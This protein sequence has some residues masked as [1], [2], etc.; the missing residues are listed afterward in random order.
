MRLS[1][2]QFA[3]AVRAAGKAVGR[4]NSCTKRLV[5]KWETGEHSACRPGY[6]TV[7]QTVTGLPARELGFQIPAVM[8]DPA[9][10]AVESPN[11]DQPTA[12]GPGT[13]RLAQFSTDVMID[14]SRDRLSLALNNPSTV[15]GRTAAFVETATDRLFDLE[16]H[17][18]ARL[19]A[20]TL[21]RHLSMVTAL[22]T[23]ARAEKVRQSLTVSAGWSSLLAGW[24]AFDQGNASAA[25]EYWADAIA[26]AE[27]TV[28]DGLF[29]ATLIFQSYATAR[30]GDP[31]TA[32][33][34]A[35]A[36]ASRTPEDPR[37]TAWATTRVAVYAA[38]L[39]AHQDALAAMGRALEIG[40]DLPNPK[41]AD[42]GTPWTRPFDH[43]R[44]LSATA[45][46]A[47]LLND[48]SALG[49]ATQA[50]AALTPAKVKSRA[51]VLAEAALAA[52]VTDQHHLCLD[53]GSAAVT[54]TRE[55]DVSLAA[56]L[57]HAVTPILLPHAN[58]HPIRE[59]L[60]QLAELTRTSDS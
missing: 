20:R 14:G 31:A 4:P 50:V 29:A 55:M 17:S 7:L 39:G 21:D 23:I 53:Y 47:A 36:A 48:P 24:L 18:P 26:A 27:A 34:L 56:D 11:D 45:H 10:C 49:Y 33:E 51:I 35:H 42:G 5:Q 6:L 41:P 25:H 59:L 3:E 30:R 58:T 1:Q 28:H 60:P 46:T 37:A 8:T 2:A 54:L 32:W 15:D 57:L 16:H 44:L 52:A 12:N 19:L 38:Q 13:P 43:A 40:W 9:G 22:L